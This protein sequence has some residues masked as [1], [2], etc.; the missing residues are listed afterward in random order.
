MYY[1]PTAPA[2][3][4]TSASM[5]SDGTGPVNMSPVGQVGEDGKVKRVLT[6]IVFSFFDRELLKYSQVFSGI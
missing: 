6:P 2:R 5:V 3:S 1:R 4:F